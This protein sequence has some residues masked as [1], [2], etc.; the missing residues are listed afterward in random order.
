MR[1]GA[2]FSFAEGFPDKPPGARNA[3]ANLP[4]DASGRWRVDLVK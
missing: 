4:T 1:L 2:G 3:F